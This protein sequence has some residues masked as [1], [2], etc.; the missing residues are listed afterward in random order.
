[1]LDLG[2]D[3]GLHGF[4]FA[5]QLTDQR[6]LWNGLEFAPLHGN[7]PID[8]PL[9]QCVPLLGP[10][11]TGIQEDLF[12]VAVQ[13]MLG[14][15]DV[16]F[17]RRRADDG[18]HQS[19]FGIDANVRLH[20]EVPLVAFPGLVHVGVTGLGFV[21]D[22]RRCGDDRGVGDGAFSHQQP[23]CGQPGVDGFEQLPG[24]LVLLQQVPELQHG[25]GIRRGLSRQINPDKGPQRLA[26][27][28]RVFDAFIR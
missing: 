9:L 14:L 19:A 10:D 21:L 8:V 23:R 26:V 24:Q 11:V 25:G 20:P 13:Q 2:A 3:T 1:M 18:V 5:Q 16:R 17:I 12:L 27:G 6:F 22:R 15:R 4:Q 28:D 7:L